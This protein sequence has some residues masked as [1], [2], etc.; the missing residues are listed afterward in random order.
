MSENF[1]RCMRT[2]VSQFGHQKKLQRSL[3][4]SANLFRFRHRSHLS[5]PARTRYLWPATAQV[6]K[7][8]SRSWS[9]LGRIYHDWL[10]LLLLL[11]L[12]LT[13]LTCSCL[14]RALSLTLSGL[15]ASDSY[16]MHAWVFGQITPTSR[17]YIDPN[18]ALRSAGYGTFS[19]DEPPPRCISW[20]P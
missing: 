16:E 7:R 8:S 15:F 5:L 10:L 19:P 3:T 13:P 1:S 6:S 20:L 9:S 4:C 18:R 11:R 2:V 17:R 12:M 14:I